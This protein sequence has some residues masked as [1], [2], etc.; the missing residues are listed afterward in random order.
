MKSKM[1]TLLTTK[2]VPQKALK[3][4]NQILKAV[5]IANAKKA[6]KPVTVGAKSVTLEQIKQV[7]DTG[8]DTMKKEKFMTDYI[9]QDLFTAEDKM[10]TIL[11]TELTRIYKEDRTAK[12]SKVK[13]WVKT[14]LQ[15]LIKESSVQERVLGD[16]V[17][18]RSITIKK[19]T[20]TMIDNKDGLYLGNFSELDKDDFK[21][22]IMKKV[23]EELSLEE[24]LQKWMKSVNLHDKESDTYEVELVRGLLDNIEKGIS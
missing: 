5:K 19:V 8:I 22:V 23:K 18:D 24:S 11:T 21:M 16:K 3:G 1:N 4:S 17:K 13:K 2:E 15:T 12:V 10:N 6:S 20:Q 9:V 14:R 7:I